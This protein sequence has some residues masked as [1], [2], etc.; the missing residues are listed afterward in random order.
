MKKSFNP[1]DYYNTT[2][3]AKILGYKRNTI[4]IRAASGYYKNVIKLDYPK[5]YYL[6]HKKEIEAELLDRKKM[7]EHLALEVAANEMIAKKKI[8]RKK[9]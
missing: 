4:Q 6:I 8:K 2:E 3:A 7:A 5:T 1:E 9:S